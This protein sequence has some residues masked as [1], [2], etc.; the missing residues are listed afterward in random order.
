MPTPPL[1]EAAD[2]AVFPGAP[3]AADVVTSVDAAMRAAAGWHIAPQITE[4]V[5]VDSD[6]GQYLLLP[7]LWLDSVTEIRDVNE[8]AIVSS[9]DVQ[10]AKTPRFRAGCLYRGSAWPI[11]PV[12]LDIVHGYE[13]CPAELLALAAALCRSSGRDQTI[14]Q[15]AAGPF[16]VTFSQ[17]AQSELEASPALARYTIPPRA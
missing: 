12:E 4:T 2:L 5:V 10:T 16:S 3:F 6:G 1:F 17:I 15:Q 9:D 7:T 8:N 11:G 14:Q 13:D